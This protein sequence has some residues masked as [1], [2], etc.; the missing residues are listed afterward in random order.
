MRK[1][2]DACF[3]WKNQVVGDG[4]FLILCG[5]ERI[6]GHDFGGSARDVLPWKYSNWISD[7]EAGETSFE[8]SNSFGLN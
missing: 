4:V 7:P 8:E 1:K 2:M 6:S 5:V 3:C